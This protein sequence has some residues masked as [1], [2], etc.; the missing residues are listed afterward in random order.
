M[1]PPFP[2]SQSGGPGLARCR[3]GS[4]GAIQTAARSG[5]RSAG[6]LRGTTWAALVALRLRSGHRRLGWF[7]G[8]PCAYARAAIGSEGP[9]LARCR[10][11]SLGAVPAPSRPGGPARRPGHL[12]GVRPGLPSVALSRALGAAKRLRL[13]AHYVAASSVGGPPRALAAR[14]PARSSPRRL[15]GRL[16]PGPPPTSGPGVLFGGG[17]R[18]GPG[19]PPLSAGGPGGP[20]LFAACAPAPL[21]APAGP[22]SAR[23]GSRLVPAWPSCASLARAAGAGSFPGSCASLVPG[24]SRPGG[25]SLRR[26]LAS[27][28]PGPP[29]GRAL[30]VPLSGRRGG[31]AP[32]LRSL[33]AP[34][35]GRG[36][37]RLRSLH[38]ARYRSPLPGRFA[39]GLREYLSREPQHIVESCSLSS[40]M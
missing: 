12:R 32:R 8:R 14:R 5:C 27:P 3:A 11:G 9:G 38:G 26:G 21:A 30:P 16:A 15:A 2:C 33:C 36:V 34:P 17:R 23:P 20:P 13:A 25:G 18:G 6:R 29:P 19:R 10:A 24:S 31:L 39:S 7:P 22:P 4:L 37:G 35:P 1:S 40:H 28:R